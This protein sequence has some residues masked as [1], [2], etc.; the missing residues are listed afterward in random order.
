M[1][2][3]TV[4]YRLLH[5]VCR[6]LDCRLAPTMLASSVVTTTSVWYL[7]A[8]SV[9]ADNMSVDLA[10]IMKEL[11]SVLSETLLYAAVPVGAV[12]ITMAS[13][14]LS[15]ATVSHLYNCVDEYASTT[16]TVDVERRNTVR[17]SFP[18]TP[19]QYEL[20]NLLLAM[21]Q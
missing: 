2:L 12:M 10:L 15:P 11:C 8:T 20:E 4:N 1:V 6:H 16:S 17:V 19:V 14:G 7:L 13:S 21:I 18:A 5:S 3:L 9:S